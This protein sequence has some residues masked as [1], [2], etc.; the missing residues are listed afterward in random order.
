MVFLDV[1][2]VPS[3][4][5]TNT[6]HLYANTASPDPT[7]LSTTP[8]PRLASLHAESCFFINRENDL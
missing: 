7:S 2:F 1:A 3:Q 4:L 5:S 6:T 8:V